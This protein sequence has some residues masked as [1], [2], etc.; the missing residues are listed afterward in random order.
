MKYVGPDKYS[1]TLKQ[2]I[3]SNCSN[4]SN[5]MQKQ[6]GFYLGGYSRKWRMK[7]AIFPVFEIVSFFRSKKI[8]KGN[9]IFE[10]KKLSISNTGKMALFIRHFLEYSPR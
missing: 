7:S 4:L 2:L 10:P 3:F 9:Y 5:K 6:L 8:C 1:I